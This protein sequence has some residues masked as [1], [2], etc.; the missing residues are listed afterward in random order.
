MIPDNISITHNYTSQNS[1]ITFHQNF[2]EYL[3]QYIPIISSH[4]KLIFAT[5]EASNIFSRFNKPIDFLPDSIVYINTGYSFNNTIVLPNN[6]KTLV[7]GDEFNQLVI[8]PC[9][10]EYLVFGW[11]FDQ[12]ICLEH[13]I[14]LKTLHFG[15]SFNQ[16]VILPCSIEHLVFGEMFNKTV[17]LPLG[18][19]TIEFGDYFNQMVC[20]K[21]LNC[22][23]DLVFGWEFNQPVRL[24]D[25][26]THLTLGYGFVQ[27]IVLPKKLLYLSMYGQFSNGMGSR[28]LLPESVECLVLNS[29]DE[30]VVDNLPCGLK[31]IVLGYNFT[32]RLDNLPN[33]VQDICFTNGL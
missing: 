13:C 19:Q 25:N 4:T 14:H 12:K 30:F 5:D 10:I 8:L 29:N 24:P 6:L 20:L 22:L 23:T 16:D 18:I 31:R 21:D 1:T 28:V 17:S 15:K 7:F 26:L 2:D 9:S 27:P 32:I 11:D 3:T 33:S